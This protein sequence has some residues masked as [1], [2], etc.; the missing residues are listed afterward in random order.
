MGDTIL[1]IKLGA[2]GDFIQSLGPM[3]AIRQFHP[4]DTLILLTT[5]PYESLARL[6][7]YFDDVICDEKPKWFEPMKWLSLTKIL[8]QNNIVRVYDLQNND[9]TSIYFRL[10]KKKPEWVG[11]AFG[12]SHRNT[13]PKRTSGKAFDGHVQT[14]ALAGIKN[15]SIDTLN[16]VQGDKNFNDLAKPYV[17]IVAGGSE[18]HPQKRWPTDHYGA[19]CKKLV[20]N[21]FTPILI[22]TKAERDANEKIKSIENSCIDLTG[23]TVLFDLPVLARGAYGTIGNDTGP[24]HLIAPTGCRSI[25][26]FSGTTH[27]HRH[28]PLGANVITIQ[29]NN[30]KDLSPDKVFDI[31]INQPHSSAS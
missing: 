26:L 1:V 8:N 24:M 22:G 4:H 11:V 10:F 25:V 28:A 15:I 7:G 5:N 13:S 30:L 27:P 16:W 6:S 12:A 31:F 19:L 23:Q 17:L 18:K 14:L 21:N 20:Q 2:L 3:A 29:E 9:R